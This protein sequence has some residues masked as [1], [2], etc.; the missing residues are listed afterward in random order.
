M[1]GYKLIKFR[2][3]TQLFAVIKMAE[4]LGCMDNVRPLLHQSLEQSPALHAAAFDHA[5][6]MLLAATQLQ[7]AGLFRD[8]TKFLLGK[9]TNEFP[10]TKSSFAKHAAIQ[11]SL[12][13]AAVTLS[14]KIDTVERAITDA[15]ASDQLKDVCIYAHRHYDVLTL[16][17]WSDNPV[18]ELPESCSKIAFPNYC[19]TL[20]QHM[21]TTRPTTPPAKVKAWDDLADALAAILESDLMFVK[22]D[23]KA[24]EGRFRDFLLCAE[25]LNDD[26]PWNIKKV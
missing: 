15:W 9:W 19:R 10:M 1:Y 7:H 5:E 26:F 12:F 24:G 20:L 14:R 2:S 23:E 18:P 3:P 13:R 17:R 16:Y 4:Y 25:V 8:C 22:K 6:S 11:N 21:T